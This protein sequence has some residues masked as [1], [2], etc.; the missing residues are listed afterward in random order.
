MTLHIYVFGLNNAD[1][2]LCE[3]TD[4]DLNIIIRDDR[5]EISSAEQIILPLTYR[6][7]LQGL[8]ESEEAK[9]PTS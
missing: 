1:S 4:E 3:E 9:Y 7:N 5:S 6:E 2:V 8:L